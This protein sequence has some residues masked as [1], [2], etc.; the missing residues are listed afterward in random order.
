ML[1]GLSNC[2]NPFTLIINDVPPAINNIPGVIIITGQVFSECPQN[3][4][5]S[6]QRRS[7]APRAAPGATHSATSLRETAASMRSLIL[8]RI[9]HVIL[10]KILINNLLK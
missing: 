7:P 4:P 2:T 9:P 3:H 10:Y 8:I 5:R 1:R 6:I